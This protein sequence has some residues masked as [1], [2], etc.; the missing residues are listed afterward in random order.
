MKNVRYY[1][2]YIITNRNKTVL[3]LGITNSIMRRLSE[4]ADLRIAGFSNRYRCKY[5]VYYEKHTYVNNAISREK[6]IKK[7]NRKKKE[8]LINQFNPEWKFLN[9]AVFSTAEE[10]L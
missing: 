8:H 6:E 2:V 3:Y 10:F 7:W 9:K 1:Y 5:L 4:H